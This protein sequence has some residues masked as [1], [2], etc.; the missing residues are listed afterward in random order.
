MQE[1]HKLIFKNDDFTNSPHNLFAVTT[2]LF[3]VA[4]LNCTS[5]VPGQ[6]Q[7]Q[8]HQV[9]GADVRAAAGVFATNNYKYVSSNYKQLQTCFY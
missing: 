1:L 3:V 9:E 8:H 2:N 6:A 4:P 7:H 5:E